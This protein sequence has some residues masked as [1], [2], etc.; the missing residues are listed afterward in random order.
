METK[1]KKFLKRLYDLRKEGMD[2]KEI[3]AELDLEFGIN[4]KSDTL[5]RYHDEYVA[6]S[7]VIVTQ[8][9]EEK[10]EAAGLVKDHTDRIGQ[11]FKQID[12]IVS[13]LILRTEQIM[14]NLDQEQFVKHI[15]TLLAVCREILNQLYFLKKDQEKLVLNQKNITYS[16]LQINQLINKEIKNLDKYNKDGDINVT[17]KTKDRFLKLMKSQKTSSDNVLTLLIESYINAH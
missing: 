9:S 15:P 12:R 13:K 14:E 6:K 3:A 11:K 8:L 17:P 16:P 7:Y 10:K 1:N 5:K 2:Y 4:L